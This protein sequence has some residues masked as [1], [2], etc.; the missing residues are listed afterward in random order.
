MIR[1]ATLLA[2]LV[3]ATTALPAPAQWIAVGRWGSEGNFR[4]VPPGTWM[5]QATG[6]GIGISAEGDHH[7]GRI[8]L[9]CSAAEPAGRLRFSGYRGEGLDASALAGEE[10]RRQPVQFV[11]DGQS[12]ERVFDYRPDERDWVAGAVLDGPFLNALAGG[13]RLELRNPGGEAIT[14]FRL[15]GS[16]AA[17]SAVQQRCGL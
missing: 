8:E 14:A 5:V 10:P 4:Y 9:W 6:D 17:R 16:R 1:A 11:I 7:Q 15:D 12:F 2:A 13:Q 3:L